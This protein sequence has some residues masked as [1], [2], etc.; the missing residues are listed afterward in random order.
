MNLAEKKETLM[1]IVEEADNKLTGLLIAVA[2]EY[3]S[4]NEAYT[5][6]EIQNFYQIRDKLLNEPETAHSPSQAHDIIRNKS[7]NAI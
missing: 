6:E 5:P 7:R 1:H 3:N 4:T 2:N